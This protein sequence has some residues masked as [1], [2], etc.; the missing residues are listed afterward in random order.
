MQ[1][2]LC[3]PRLVWGIPTTLLRSHWHAKA[4]VMLCCRGL[5]IH[6]EKASESCEL[7]LVYLILAASLLRVVA[8]LQIISKKGRS[9]VNSPPFYFYSCAADFRKNVWWSKK[10]CKA[11]N[12]WC[13]L[14]RLSEHLCYL[15][16]NFHQAG[17][18]QK[19][20]KSFSTQRGQD[21]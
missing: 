3:S 20:Q 16:I 19:K 5:Q 21:Q 1:Q 7:D 13:L 8:Q 2:C 12:H 6:V 10:I 17:T 4:P 18:W 9:W 11:S 15:T 14:L